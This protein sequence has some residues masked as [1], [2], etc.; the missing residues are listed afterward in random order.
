[1]SINNKY[2]RDENGEIFYPIVDGN[3]IPSDIDYMSVNR[4]FELLRNYGLNGYCPI[5]AIT[6]STNAGKY[7]K[8]FEGAMTGVWDC[9]IFFMYVVGTEGNNHQQL[10]SFAERNQNNVGTPFKSSIAVI[11]LYQSTIS[12]E[13]SYIPSASYNLLKY[14][15]GRVELYVKLNVQH[16]ATYFNP[17]F[18]NCT[19]IAYPRNGIAD[20]VDTLPTENVVSVCKGELARYKLS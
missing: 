19:S 5:K 20:A 9:L 6:N 14:N 17:I 3:S 10:I 8:V 13:D 15:D 7:W 4:R 18:M 2:L 11:N 12:K 1:M 16:S